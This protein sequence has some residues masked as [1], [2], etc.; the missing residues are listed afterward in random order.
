MRFIDFLVYYPATNFKNRK[1]GGWSYGSE[2]GRAVFLASLT[3]SLFSFAMV[4]FGAFLFFKINLFDFAYGSI[5]LLV[6][7][8]LIINRIFD[9]I[10]LTKKRYDHICSSPSKPFE[11]NINIGV[12]LCFL[13]FILS[14]LCVVVVA[15]LIDR[16]L[17][18]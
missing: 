4:E 9:F 5:G 12:A 17:K 6:A 18:K 14:M 10:Y 8:G 2:L 16:L 7:G 15:V 1:M 3:I 13:L 11:L